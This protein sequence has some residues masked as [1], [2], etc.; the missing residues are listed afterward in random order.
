MFFFLFVTADL[1]NAA[2]LLVHQSTAGQSEQIHR[3]S[4]ETGVEI[5]QSSA[6]L[7]SRRRLHPQYNKSQA[8]RANIQVE[9]E[10][11]NYPAISVACTASRQQVRREGHRRYLIARACQCV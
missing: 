8:T 7:L 9:S 3:E 10:I 4:N 1:H 2:R 6:A 11:R 5:E